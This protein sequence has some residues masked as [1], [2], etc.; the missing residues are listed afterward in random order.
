[1]NSAEQ[2]Q[3]ARTEFHRLLDLDVDARK[4][5]L[6]DLHISQPSLAAQV[7]ALFDHLDD[8]D[9]S[10]RI[11]FNALPT[12][13]GPFVIDHKL[14]SGG[15]GVVYAAHRGEV[16]FEQRVAL[17]VVQAL[18][19]NTEAVQRFHRERA[20]LARLKHRNIAHLVEGGLDTQTG[21]S[22]FA[23]ELVEG[24]SITRWSD[25]NQ[26]NIE[27]RLNLFLSVLDAVSHAH[28][29]L[30]VHRDIKPSN[31]WVNQQGQVKLL[32]FG[33]A[34]MLDPT[35]L[36]DDDS[37]LI[38][39]PNYAAPE[40]RS[41]SGITTAVD[42]CLLGLL[43]RELIFGIAPN[44][45]EW[46]ESIELKSVATKFAQLKPSQRSAL[47]S[48][49]N[50]TER[51]FDKILRGDLAAIV[52]KACA[53]SPLERYPSASS[54]NEDIQ[55]YLQHRPVRAAR[56]SWWSMFTKLLQRNR[57][58][59]GI[60]II[61]VISL[62]GLSAYALGRARSEATERQRAEHVLGF[63]R[64]IF[65]QSAPENVDGEV[66]S[67]AELM[68]RVAKK[69]LTRGDLAP[70]TQ[71]HIAHEAAG[72]YLALGEP[73]RAKTTAQ[74]A[75]DLLQQSQEFFEPDLRNYMRLTLAQAHNELGDWPAALTSCNEGLNDAKQKDPWLRARLLT[76]RGWVY[77]RQGNYQAAQSDT[78]SAIVLFEK[79]P[80]YLADASG[81]NSQLAS[82]L[83]DQGQSQK[84]IELMQRAIALGDQAK[85]K[86]KLDKYIDQYSLAREHFRIGQY[87]QA[88]TN[89]MLLLPK[90][91][92]LVGPAHDRT[93]LARNLYAQILVREG[94]SDDAMNQL[95]NSLAAL[96]EKGS[97]A[98]LGGVLATRAKLLLYSHRY[99]AAQQ[100]IETA[101]TK[102]G[103]SNSSNN[104]LDLRVRWIQAE[105]ILQ[106]GRYAEATKLLEPINAQFEKLLQDAPSQIFSDAQDSLARA[107]L[108][109]GD[110]AQAGIWLGRAQQRIETLAELRSVAR[111]RLQAH[112]QWLRYARDKNQQAILQ[113]GELRSSI[114]TE[115]GADAIQVFE[116]DILLDQL[117]PGSIDKAQV[118]FAQQA[119]RKRAG[120]KQTIAIR[121]LMIDS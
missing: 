57:L 48:S 66:L 38:M 98:S 22:W 1:M 44:A 91:D 109:Q 27:A 56:V 31:V 39:T 15:M 24:E 17:K 40:Q 104:M 20:I 10:P 72:A 112:Q 99:E 62:I 16:D 51:A 50:I 9:L 34:K 14:G 18:V 83:S 95:E 68:D 52:A 101:M 107:Y 25:Q 86:L 35:Q 76:T 11:N 102:L 47:A 54:M 13:I 69:T 84:A 97:P 121:G 65:T 73:L 59:S 64:E 93:V 119:L 41:R 32:D 100:T 108:L 42:I 63:M 118:E 7:Q 77:F 67:A 90:M 53:R 70:L 85:D 87:D 103:T 75:L 82:I 71:A 79:D 2:F 114:Q 43:L 46:Q 61:S 37:I 30:I 21:L 106:Q 28:S 96:T 116:L 111:Q 55:N 89:L 36:N 6:I 12:Q 26:L 33:I 8:A 60:T 120:N 113:L 88:K 19:L 45:D 4:Q 78:E 58:A 115:A 49:R 5:A 117:Q 23:M 81:A 3:N 80:E 92:S 29:Q 94:N 105:A 110:Y 74:R